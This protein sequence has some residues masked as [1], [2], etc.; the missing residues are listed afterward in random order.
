MAG[1]PA[2]SGLS[3]CAGRLSGDG[4]ESTRCPGEGERW[5]RGPV[6]SPPTILWVEEKVVSEVW[7]VGLSWKEPPTC[8]RRVMIETVSDVFQV[9]QKPEA[10]TSATCYHP[11]FSAS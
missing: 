2:G 11:D 6:W 1:A 10:Q 9:V 7:L 4:G 8:E 5:S 3:S